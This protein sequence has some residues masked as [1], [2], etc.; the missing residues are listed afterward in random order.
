MRPKFYEINAT[1]K[2]YKQRGATQND[3]IENNKQNVACLGKGGKRGGG[4][5]L[6][7]P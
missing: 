5:P 6:P 2:A 1:S 4:F 3:N 7:P